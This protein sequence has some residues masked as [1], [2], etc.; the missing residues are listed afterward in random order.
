MLSRD[1]EARNQAATLSPH[2]TKGFVKELNTKSPACE[3]GPFCE[4]MKSK[5][6][7]SPTKLA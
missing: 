4:P 7:V 6:L 3:E 2:I 5:L 1:V